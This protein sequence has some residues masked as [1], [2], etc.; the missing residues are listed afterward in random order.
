MS[1]FFSI[2]FI[3]FTGG[4]ASR[5]RRVLSISVP[6]TQILVVVEERLNVGDRFPDPGVK[7]RVLT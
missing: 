3:L 5:E 6:G 4:G 1:P 7:C 2:L